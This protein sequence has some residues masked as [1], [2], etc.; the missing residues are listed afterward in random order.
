VL[1]TKSI[2]QLEDALADPE[3]DHRFPA[4]MG[5]RRM[6]GVPMLRNGAPLG[7]IVVGW[8]EAGPI[9]KAQEDL[10][11]TFA[12]QAAIA[13]ENVRLFN[14]TKEALE[15]QTATAEILKVISSSPTDVQPVFEAIARSGVHLFQGVAVILRILKGDQI[16]RVAFAAGPGCE[17]TEDAV[18]VTHALDDRSFTGRA[19]TRRELIHVP[20]VLAADWAG[21]M[22]KTSAAR[23][24]V[25]AIAVAPM[26]HEN[27]ALGTIA[28][29]RAKPAPFSTKELTLLRTFADQAV[30]ALE[31]VRLFNE[32][33]ARNRDLTEALEQQTATAEILR[34][35][36]S[37]PTD[38]TPVF[39]TIVASARRLCEANFAAALLYDG[40]RLR[41]AA[42]TTIS[43]EF[44]E[45]FREGYPVNRETA[46]GRTALSRRPVQVND[47]L[48]DR[49][50]LITP[51]HRSE[52]VRTVLAVPMLRDDVLLGVISTW[53]L[54][55]RPFSGKQIKLLE[56]FA[57]QAVIA[58]EN[59]RL[60]RELQVR[61]RDLAEALQQQTASAE[62]L[63][64]ISRSPTDVQPVFDTIVRNA[65][66]L[67]GST[68]GAVFR[69]DGELL[70]YTAGHDF[71]SEWLEAVR[72]KYPLRPDMSTVSGRAILT[73][74]LA[75]IDDVLADPQY[76]HAHAM[77]GG[78]R[79]MLAVP[80]LREGVPL[81][82]I[83]VAWAHPGSTPKSQE[84]LLRM[85]ADQAV[86][87]IENV[88][89]FQELQVR[90]R[91]LTEALEQQTATA[92]ILKVISG[93]PTDIQPV[94]DAVASTA[95][96]LCGASDALIFRIDAN[97]LHRVAMYGSLSP[98]GIG[99][100]LPVDRGTV[101]GRC[102]IDRKTIQVEDLSAA[103][104][105]EFP[106][107]RDL[108]QRLGYRTTL[109]T[110]L[111]REGQPIGAIVIRRP[112]VRPFA[113]SQIKLL[114]TFADQAVIAIENVRLFNELQAR[115]RE[116]ARSVEELR[117]LGEVGRAVSSTLDL[118]TVLTTIV[119]RALELSGADGGA[120]SEF[121]E[122]TQQFHL[123]TTYGVEDELVEVVRA[124]PI[125]L[126]EGT[127]GKAAAAR[128]PVQVADILDEQEYDVA[129]VR[130]VW[131]RYGYRSALSLPLL[132]EDR[133][134]GA[135]TVWRRQVG[136]FP[137]EVVN[138]L[139]TFA[140][141]STLAI[142]RARIFRELEYKGRELELASRHKS[143]FL[144]NM[145]HELRTP[146]N[147]VLGYTELISDSIYGEVPEKIRDVI[148]RIDR[149]GRHLLGL[150]N[151]VL[152][153][154]KIEAGQ[155]TLSLADYSM[156]EVVQTVVT[157]MESLAAEKKLALKMDVAADLPRG[158]GD[159][160]R[161][162]QVLLNLVGNAIKFTEAGEVRVEAGLEDSRFLVSVTDT[163]PGISPEDQQRIFEAFQQVDSSLTRRKGGTGLGLSI[164][165][166]IVEMHGGRLWVAS[167][168]G[169]GSTF[170]F[171]V[172]VRV[173][174]QVTA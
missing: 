40:E 129:R 140:T 86:I 117:A 119:A 114:E 31:N 108:A 63:R 83:V 145:S 159:E 42:H 69:Y 82:V 2:V 169:Q 22:S 77:K 71:T 151:D 43:A 11:K 102:V 147:A 48:E 92:E 75:K 104:E 26:L 58:I 74:S 51:A 79:R 161:L 76:D 164:A 97:R 170:S 122:T 116:L 101:G 106:L 133:I 160:R 54:E 17:V 32:L 163:G 155:L 127:S 154:S 46:T 167:I 36:S 68:N 7:A 45:Y 131:G 47:I 136:E 124:A 49:E 112:E 85:F 81:G 70:H 152:D 87:A 100:G 148:S 80:M 156:R 35:I 107:G 12:D 44:A 95:A 65:V 132:R 113:D 125:R 172:T 153:L 130:E 174:K 166:R 52:G 6:L 21:E 56:T 61:N 5:W 73:V 149:S 115:T 137:S 34:V 111:L 57:D 4:A 138:L 67:C 162:S 120:I 60:F 135:L 110:P 15:Q 55:V 37:S 28:V 109:G 8:S 103:D 91:D 173:E 66:R 3:Y 59:V 38:A 9:P 123:R 30:I 50:F 134:L 93:S 118:E 126:G 14:E 150:I 143:E 62:I 64:V 20:D 158:R 139:Q 89:L 78:W 29:T 18:T 33:Q 121:D 16:E 171:T 24:A 96:R 27:K 25:R 72:L 19:I 88:R 142:Q 41:S 90:N 10:L 84:D 168:P 53:R 13:L 146:L 144:A 99:K 98:G 105:T 141:Q 157:G 23:M 1:L 165:K 39:E 128:V 94:L